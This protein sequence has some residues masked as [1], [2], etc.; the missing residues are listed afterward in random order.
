[1]DIDMYNLIDNELLTTPYQC[2]NERDKRLCKRNLIKLYEMV[3]DNNNININNII[4]DNN[5]KFLKY[6]YNTLYY[7]LFSYMSMFSVFIIGFFFLNC[8]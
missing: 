6:H 7:L 2:M 5:N 4:L 3:Q 8:A 1:M